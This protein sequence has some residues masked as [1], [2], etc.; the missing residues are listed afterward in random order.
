MNALVC[1][2]CRSLIVSLHRH[3]FRACECGAIFVDGGNDYHRW[4]GEPGDYVTIPDLLL[5]KDRLDRLQEMGGSYT[6]RYVCRMS[7]TGRGMRLHET[8]ADNGV[9]TIREAIDRA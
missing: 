2:K 1:L 3:D 8:G 5:D 9:P 6:D 7:A 4:G